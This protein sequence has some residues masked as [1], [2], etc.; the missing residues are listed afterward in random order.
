MKHPLFMTFLLELQ[1]GFEF[2]AKTFLFLFFSVISEGVVFVSHASA[3]KTGKD[4]WRIED[5]ALIATPTRYTVLCLVI[6][7]FPNKI[8]PLQVTEVLVK[9][10]C[11]DE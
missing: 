6:W 5:Q 2:S 4:I 8:T 1:T 11:L 3:L 9:T 10:C 7:S